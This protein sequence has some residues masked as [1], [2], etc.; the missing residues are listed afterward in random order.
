ML[1]RAGPPRSVPLGRT[2]I[3]PGTWSRVPG[4]ERPGNGFWLAVRWLII[5]PC[6]G[7]R[8][9]L[10]S[11]GRPIS[12]SGVTRP[13]GF[14]GLRDLS[15]VLS[16]A[17]LALGPPCL[18]V[19]DAIRHAKL[20]SELWAIRYFRSVL[21]LPHDWR[22]YRFSP[23]KVSDYRSR[24]AEDPRGLGRLGGRPSGLCTTAE[25]PGLGFQI[26]SQ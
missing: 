5:D 17:L 19:A 24:N 22:T 21:G 16:R 23:K 9:D 4:A 3:V 12:S 25:C 8:G 14:A 6:P 18:R 13:P 15:Q 10:W 1:R 26:M 11:P 2:V 20:N 7:R